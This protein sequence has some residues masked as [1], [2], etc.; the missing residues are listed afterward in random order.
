MLVLHW[1]EV[2]FVLDVTSNAIDD[3]KLLQRPRELDTWDSVRCRPI[4]CLR[5]SS[6]S[7]RLLVLA[8]I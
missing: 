3:L 4:W 1:L 2:L 7:R 6:P 8:S 5:L